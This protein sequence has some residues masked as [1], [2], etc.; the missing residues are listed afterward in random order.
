MKLLLDENISFG[1]INKIQDLFPGLKQV[2]DL[3]LENSK[4][5]YPGLMLKII[6]IA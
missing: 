4:Y 2:K 1:I 6:I 3:G 5:S